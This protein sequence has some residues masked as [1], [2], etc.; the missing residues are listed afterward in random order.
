MIYDNPDEKITKYED[1]LTLIQNLLNSNYL[2][3]LKDKEREVFLFGSLF[4]FFRNKSNELD[5]LNIVL[6]LRKMVKNLISLRL[7]HNNTLSSVEKK[8]KMNLAI[9]YFLIDCYKYNNSKECK[10]K[11]NFRN[12]AS[13]F[14]GF[15]RYLY[16]IISY[17]FSKFSGFHLSVRNIYNKKQYEQPDKNIGPEVFSLVLESLNRKKNNMGKFYSPKNYSQYLTKEVIDKYIFKEIKK[18]GYLSSN[19][20]FDQILDL[21]ETIHIKNISHKD[22]LK[23]WKN[24]VNS[25]FDISLCDNACGTGEFLV[26]SMSY[27]LKLHKKLIQIKKHLFPNDEM[28]NKCYNYIY[29]HNDLFLLCNFMIQSNLFGVDNDLLAIFVAKIRLILFSHNYCQK[30]PNSIYNY[31]IPPR[32]DIALGDSLLGY[33]FGVLDPLITHMD[34][35]QTF[36]E[37]ISKLQKIQNQ[38]NSVENLKKILILKNKIKKELDRA[39]INEYICNLDTLKENNTSLDKIRGNILFFHWFL[40]FNQKFLDIKKEI[41]SE[42]DQNDFKD[43]DFGFDIIFGNPPYIRHENIKK[44][45]PNFVYYKDL[46]YE[47]YKKIFSKF[48]SIPHSLFKSIDYSMYF[49]IR[50]YDLI[51]N[52][53]FHSYLITAKWQRARYGRAIRSFLKNYLKI[54]KVVDFKGKMDI[55]E[56]QIDLIIYISSK[57]KT[58]NSS[59]IEYNNPSKIRNIESFNK[60]GFVFPQNKL[61]DDGWRFISPLKL[62]IKEYVEKKG[63]SI[64]NLGFSVFRGITTGYNKAFIIEEEIKNTLTKTE[65]DNNI[66]SPILKGKDVSKYFINW[67]NKWII[68][69]KQGI[70]IE[71]YPS[72]KKYLNQYKKKLKPKPKNYEKDIN[73]RWSGRKSGSYKWYEIQDVTNYHPYFHYP[74]IIF[75]ELSKEPPFY[76]DRKSFWILAK[77]NMIVPTKKSLNSSLKSVTLILNSKLTK[78]YYDFFGIELNYGY[79]FKVH[80]VERMPIILPLDWQYP[81]LD[82][83]YDILVFLFI[84][85]ELKFLNIEEIEQFKDFFIKLADF[86]VYEIYFFDLI[87]KSIERNYQKSNTLTSYISDKLGYFGDFNQW[88]DKY[89]EIKFKSSKKTINLIKRDFQEINKNLFNSIEMIYEEIN[90]SQYSSFVEKIKRNK[91]VKKIEDF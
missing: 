4:L 34:N 51:K 5:M 46:L 91:Y 21:L 44:I 87:Y 38:Q 11:R 13:S 66:I 42:R 10:K 72:I 54:H 32:L 3:F 1:F 68:F 52:N 58:S 59:L 29:K 41:L 81:L 6:S 36:F 69:T 84:N 12:S 19:S 43:K 24:C 16:G 82:N 62:E 53:S 89:W 73:K 30:K 49:I 9:N 76:Y 2:F 60:N 57:N 15:S 18:T 56:A 83:L 47:I 48:K 70:D 71:K 67:R 39:Y 50:S 28:E 35:F 27:L 40:E 75:K 31:Y 55:R 86:A 63:D 85:K 37:K 61:E 14:V 20:N 79:E 88:E 77:V 33:G 45:N 26:T 80:R 7:N 90:K 22:A 78:F 64:S 23:L 25:L 65:S 8:K 17:L 74:K